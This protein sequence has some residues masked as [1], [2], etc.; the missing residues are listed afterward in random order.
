MT[1]PTIDIDLTSSQKFFESK[2]FNI[3]DKDGEPIIVGIGIRNPE[4]IGG[5]IRLAGTIGC[6]EVII[7]T[8]IKEHKTAKIKKTATTAFNKIAW[9]FAKNDEWIELIPKEYTIIA[10]ETTGDSEMIFDAKWPKKVAFV[11]GDERYGIDVDNVNLCHK[12]VYIPMIGSVKSLNVVQATSIALYEH[13]RR[14]F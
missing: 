10:L 11:V 5:L 8:D 14:N 6:K 2:I 4:N 3:W 12:K 1:K 9:K 7:T 13:L